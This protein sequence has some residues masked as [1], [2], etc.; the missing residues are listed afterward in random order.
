M[1]EKVDM[2]FEFR[3]FA[4]TGRGTRVVFFDHVTCREVLFDRATLK[5][6]LVNLERQG[7]AHREEEKTLARWPEK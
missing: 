1:T 6:R 4:E 3:K 2:E 5:T 7:R